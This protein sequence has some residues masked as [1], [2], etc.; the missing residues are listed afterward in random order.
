M[1]KLAVF[2]IVL[3]LALALSACAYYENGKFY[4]P[5]I[6]RRK[7]IEIAVNEAG[8]ARNDVRDLDVEFDVKRGVAVW[9]VDFEYSGLEY[10]YDVDAETGAIARAEREIDR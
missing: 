2:S 3:V 5:D 7:A 10:S 8:V 4:N 9:E 6:N 1:R